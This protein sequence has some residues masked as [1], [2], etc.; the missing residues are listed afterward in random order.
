MEKTV[1]VTCLNN[2]QDYDIPMGSN[3]SEA[4]QLMN[5]T[6]EHEPILAHV[7][8]KV[9]GMHYRIYKPKRVEFLDIT[10]ASGQ[11]CCTASHAA[12]LAWREVKQLFSESIAIMTF[13]ATKIRI[14]FHNDKSRPL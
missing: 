12:S 14:N 10:S 11:R 6:M 1:K 7:N 5:L 2:G 9:E 3:L 4:L 13:I 8:N